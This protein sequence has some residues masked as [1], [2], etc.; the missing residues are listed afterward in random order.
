[1]T[2]D[3]QVLTSI[4][5]DGVATVKVSP[6][7]HS[8]RL[9]LKGYET[10]S[11]SI[12]ANRNERETLLAALVE[13]PKPLSPTGTKGTLS[14]RTNVDKAEIL[15][16]GQ[17]KGVTEQ[18]NKLVT[19]GLDQGVYTIQ[20]RKPGYKASR[21]QQT[22]IVADRE[23]QLSFDLSA[24]E[25]VRSI[26]RQKTST[27]EIVS[28][29]AS[30]SRI[31]MGQTVTLK[32]LVQNVV[33]TH[34]EPGVGAVPPS[35]TKDVMPGQTTTYI[36]TAK[37]QSGRTTT[38]KVFLVIEPQLPQSRSTTTA[39]E[40]SDSQHIQ[41]TLARF[42]GAYDSMDIDALRREWPSLTPTHA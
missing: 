7:T 39:A 36:L 26:A 25:D 6:G 3:E 4:G 15:V 29:T 33:N 40:V 17:P 32:W 18:A 13:T 24:S 21:E 2:I 23:N 19:V 27:P 42:K 1:M 37:G 41:E 38:A 8:L 22:E 28:F 9:S 31:A 34:I 14:V 10:Y 35:G 20:L 5:L 11:T 12:K 16:D 30:Q